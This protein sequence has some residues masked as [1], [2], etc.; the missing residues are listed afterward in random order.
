MFVALHGIIY[1]A[2]SSFI[3]QN[4]WFCAYR[5]QYIRDNTLT[6]NLLSNMEILFMIDNLLSQHSLCVNY[7]STEELNMQ[8]WIKF[9]FF[10]IYFN[11]CFRIF[12]NYIIIIIIADIQLDAVLSA[13]EKSKWLRCPFFTWLDKPLLYLIYSYLFIYD[14]KKES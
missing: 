14:W 6:L 9:L 11:L 10:C 4:F 7:C 13:C 12:M 8:N 3:S 1:S 2:G 5:F